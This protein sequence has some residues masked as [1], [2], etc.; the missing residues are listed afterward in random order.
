MPKKLMMPDG[1]SYE[2]DEAVYDGYMKLKSDME[3]MTADMGDMRKKYD[4]AMSKM[5]AMMS[6][7]MDAK[8]EEMKMKAKADALQR[9][10]DDF[11]AQG[12]RPE[13]EISKLVEKELR[14]RADAIRIASALTP[15][16]KVGLNQTANEIEEKVVKKLRIDGVP[17]EN[18][19]VYLKAYYDYTVNSDRVDDGDDLDNYDDDYDDYDDD[20]DYRSDGLVNIDDLF[21]GGEER[22]S[23]RRGRQLRATVE[24]RRRSR[25]DEGASGWDLARQDELERWMMAGDMEDGEL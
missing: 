13:D 22:R 5:D 6:K 3:K 15:G 10:L 20:D 11:E 7:T 24:G 1:M 14:S 4:E 23:S 2:V 12:K 19:S 9:R 18:R 17:E 8:E 21:G 25:R 16:L